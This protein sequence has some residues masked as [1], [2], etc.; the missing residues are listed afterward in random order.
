M[1]A[2]M[3][4]PDMVVEPESIHDSEAASPLRFAVT[5]ASNESGAESKA[6]VDRDRAPLPEVPWL[7]AA[8][9]PLSKS[10]HW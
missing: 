10:A 5:D 1:A 6:A 3:V 2:A 9:I 7:Q 4:T 8:G